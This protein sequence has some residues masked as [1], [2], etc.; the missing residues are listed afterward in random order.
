MYRV[1]LVH[2][3]QVYSLNMHITGFAPRPLITGL[4]VG[5]VY[6]F[7]GIVQWDVD[8]KICQSD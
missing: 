7:K 3:E 6:D 1:T 5:E 4:T 8:L 2:Q